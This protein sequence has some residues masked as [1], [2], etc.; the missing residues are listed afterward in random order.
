MKTLIIT[1]AMIMIVSGCTQPVEPVV[2]D[3]NT[4]K[5]TDAVLKPND[6]WLEKFGITDDTVIFYNLAV[7]K[8]I[9]TQL[10]ARI[11]ALEQV[12]VEGVV[13]TPMAAADPN[14]QKVE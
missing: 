11:K 8:Q 12:G 4:P 5:M 14:A 3:P 7:Y 2:T 10:D 13:V 6:I 9:L 1:L